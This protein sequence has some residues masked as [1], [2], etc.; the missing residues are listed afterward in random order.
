MDNQQGPTVQHKELCSILCNNLNGR[1]IWKRIDTRTYITESLC[2]TPE[3]NT[4]LLINCSPNKIKIKKKKD[5]DIYCY[6]LVFPLLT[7]S[8]Y[9]I[10]EKHVP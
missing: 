8:A 3:T 2:C 10:P 4:T 7:P 5:P 6:V 9:Y 1:R